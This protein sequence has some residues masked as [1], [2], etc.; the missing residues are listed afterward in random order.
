MVA[1]TMTMITTITTTM[2]ITIDPIAPTGQTAPSD[3]IVPLLY[4]QPGQLV[5]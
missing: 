5:A 4:R 1:I 3:Q 2:M